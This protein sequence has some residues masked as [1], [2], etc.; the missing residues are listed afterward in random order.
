MKFFADVDRQIRH[1]NGETHVEST[2]II[3]FGI[4]LTENVIIDVSNICRAHERS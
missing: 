4:E 2:V 3:S 1:R